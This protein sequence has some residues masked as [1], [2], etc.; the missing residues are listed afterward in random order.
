[1]SSRIIE[2]LLERVVL[3]NGRRV[4]NVQTGML[5]PATDRPTDALPRAADS[6]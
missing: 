5:R 6:Q 1:M 4:R 2:R 3:R